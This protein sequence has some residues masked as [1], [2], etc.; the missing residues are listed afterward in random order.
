MKTPKL[1]CLNCLRNT[2]LNKHDILVYLHLSKDGGIVWMTPST[3]DQTFFL[4]NETEKRTVQS[5]NLPI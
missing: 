5:K 2:H 1:T 4:T 3:K